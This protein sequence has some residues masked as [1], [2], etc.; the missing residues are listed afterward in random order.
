MSEGHDKLQNAHGRF[1]DFQPSDIERLLRKMISEGLLGEELK[2]LQHDNIVS[3]VKLGDLAKKFYTADDSTFEFPVVQNEKTVKQ[4]K[5]PIREG[6][7]LSERLCQLAYE[8]LE[9]ASREI[10]AKENV[11]YHNILPLETLREISNRLPNSEAEMLKIPGVTKTLFDKYGQKYL[12][13][14]QEHKTM[15]EEQRRM[16]IDDGGLFEDMDDQNDDGDNEGIDFD[17]VQQSDQPSTSRGY[18]GRA[19]KWKGGKKAFN[20]FS[21]RNSGGIGKK[22]TTAKKS[23]YFPARKTKKKGKFDFKKDSW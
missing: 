7:Q 10:A 5:L 2:F 16:Q 23:P 12:K 13:V 11:H 15:L 18:G 9:E 22:K 4:N 17:S 21:R 14:S 6:D 3:Y 1:K 19:S 20:S 8:A